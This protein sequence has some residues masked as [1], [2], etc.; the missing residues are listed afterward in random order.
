[1]DY[2]PASTPN[3]QSIFST[4]PIP[5]ARSA[6]KPTLLAGQPN[7]ARVE[8]DDRKFSVHIF[9]LA[10]TVKMIFLTLKV[11]RFNG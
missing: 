6:F 3:S 1:M 11:D 2:G 7:A 9:Y 5:L 4:W 8:K 10:S